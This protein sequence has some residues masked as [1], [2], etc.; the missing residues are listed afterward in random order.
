VTA[1]SRAASSSPEVASRSTCPSD[2]ELA[3]FVEGSLP[4][5]ARTGV[6]AHLGVCDDCR[7]IVATAAAAVPPDTERPT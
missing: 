5:P 6:V 1:D 4:A 3:Q 2:L 7:E